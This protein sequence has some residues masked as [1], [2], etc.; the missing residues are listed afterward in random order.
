M[1]NE[2]T[3]EIINRFRGQQVTQNL[4]DEFCKLKH[5]D[6][7]VV[8]EYE[9]RLFQ[10]EHDERVAS[11]LP[12]IFAELMKWQY[13][14]TYISAGED[15]KLREENEDIEWRIAKVLEDKGIQ[16]KEIDTATKNIGNA[17]QHIMT[18]AGNRASNM[19]VVVL[20][21]L[22]KDK[23]G[24]PLVLKP[25]AEFYRAKAKE[26]GVKLHRTQNEAS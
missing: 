3:R 20:A 23:F 15:K 12:D 4:L 17:L 8:S 6:P 26:L 22:A 19:C 10:Q 18:M 5:F 2:Q 24:D 21:T 11:A 7:I 16:Y 25:I 14:P 9:D 13:I 1:K